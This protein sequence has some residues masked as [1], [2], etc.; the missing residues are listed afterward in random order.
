MCYIVLS[1]IQLGATVDYAILFTV[2]YKRYLD[3]MSAKEAAYKALSESGVS[4]IT[5]VAIMAGC[6]LSV[7]FVS[8]NVVIGDLCMMIARGS[9]I[10]GL[11]VL[12]LLPG[13]LVLCTGNRRARRPLKIKLPTHRKI[14]KVKV[15][16]KVE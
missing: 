13:L 6:C 2:K 11:L 7:T 8:S 14:D 1:A 3:S 15:S 16:D 10:S 4:V 9:L 5:S 12:L